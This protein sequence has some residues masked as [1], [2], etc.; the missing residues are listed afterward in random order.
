M[1]LELAFNY[2]LGKRNFNCLKNTSNQCYFYCI[3]K[4]LGNCF[5]TKAWFLY[6][7]LRI[8]GNSWRSLDRWMQKIFLDR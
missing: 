8:F 3:T 7:Q 4:G 1:G 5:K 6:D 2:A